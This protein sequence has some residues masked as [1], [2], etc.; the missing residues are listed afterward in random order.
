MCVIMVGLRLSAGLIRSV[1]RFPSDNHKR[2][3]ES[4]ALVGEQHGTA[5]SQVQSCFPM[6]FI[7]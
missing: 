2:V 7:V 6:T 5:V 4:R 1:C 3:L